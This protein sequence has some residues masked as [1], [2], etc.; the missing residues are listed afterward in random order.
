[1]TLYTPSVALRAGLTCTLQV[2]PSS[3]ATAAGSAG[4]GCRAELCKTVPS[5]FHTDLSGLCNKP[6]MTSSTQLLRQKI[7]VRKTAE[8]R[9]STS[10]PGSGS[11]SHSSFLPWLLPDAP[12]R[13]RLGA[14]LPNPTTWAILGP[15][16]ASFQMPELLCGIVR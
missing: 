1:M 13:R 15:S 3:R 2:F 10:T 5:S 6:Q 14:R 8:G 4:P 12:G 9:V 11:C 7:T 16:L